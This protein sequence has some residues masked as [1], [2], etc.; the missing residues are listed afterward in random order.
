[1]RIETSKELVRNVLNEKAAAV[2][3][4]E[5][6]GHG[7]QNRGLNISLTLK[8]MKIEAFYF[9]KVDSSGYH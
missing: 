4:D 1:M 9:C 5:Q 3:S 6:D 2:S 7:D 8:M